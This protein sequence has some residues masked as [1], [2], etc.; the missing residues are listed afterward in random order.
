MEILNQ[1]TLTELILILFGV[2]SAAMALLKIIDFFYDKLKR[3]FSKDKNTEDV[4]KQLEEKQKELDE[5]LSRVERSIHMLINSD[6]NDIKT[7]IVAKHR[8]LMLQQWV[9]A[10]DL[11]CI[12]RR[13]ADYSQEGGNSYV[14]DLIIDIRKL[15]KVQP[16]TTN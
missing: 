15:P 7:W 5:K 14:E 9:D 11:D 1:Y 2:G 13:F 16:A 4:T 3:K 8:Q 12:E 6:K 10:Y